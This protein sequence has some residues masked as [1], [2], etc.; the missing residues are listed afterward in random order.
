M[1]ITQLT[2]EGK[3]LTVQFRYAVEYVQRMKS[4]T[5]AHFD[6]IRKLWLF[7]ITSLE[8]FESEFRGEIIWKTPLWVIKQMPMP[9]M[10]QMYQISETIRCPEGKL[11]P[12]SHQVFGTRFMIDRLYKH[13]FVINADD[14]GIGIAITV[15]PSIMNVNESN[16]G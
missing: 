14:V 8:D 1:L 10:S 3:E 6:P 2:P 7:P 5:G 13:G 11:Q 15:L 4:I 16:N 9:D 12:F